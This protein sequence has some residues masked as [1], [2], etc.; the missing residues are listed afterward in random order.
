MASRDERGT[1]LREEGSLSM[2]FHQAVGERQDQVHPPL[3]GSP[4]DDSSADLG[5]LTNPAVQ[6]E[7]PS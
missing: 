5:G 2:V 4:D 7:V 1:G 3:L 6:Q